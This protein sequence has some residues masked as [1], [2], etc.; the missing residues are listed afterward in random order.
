M[1]E[2]QFNQFAAEGYNRIPLVLETFAD[3]DT[4][5][6]V[7][8]KLANRPVHLPARIDRRRR[9]FRPLFVHRARSRNPSRSARQRVQRIR[10]RRVDAP[11]AGRRPAAVHPA[12]SVPLQGGCAARP[13][14][15]LRG[16]RRLLRYDTV[17]YIE[18][19]LAGSHNPIRSRARY[20]AAAVAGARDSSNNLSGKLTLVVYADP[21]ERNAY[22]AARSRLAEL[23]AKLRAPV[24]IPVDVSVASEPAVSGFGE[25]AYH[26]AVERAKR[27]I[28]RRATSCRWCRRS[29]CPSVFKGDAARAVSRAAHHQSVAVHVLL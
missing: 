6:S 17:R 11:H 4:P 24:A 1:T 9:A 20:P 13:A 16:T 29:A 28:F 5:L 21:G 10:A 19:R 15:F 7:Y 3:L 18:R 14:A 23:L 25:A 2:S 26:A 12:V 22:R 27:Y 8:L